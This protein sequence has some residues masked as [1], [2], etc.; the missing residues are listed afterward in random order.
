MTIYTAYESQHSHNIVP[1]FQTYARPMQGLSFPPSAFQPF[2]LSASVSVYP[3]C[4]WHFGTFAQVAIPQF[5]TSKCHCAIGTPVS[6]S[7]RTYPFVLFSTTHYLSI[8]YTKRTFGHV[9]LLSYFDY[10]TQKS[11]NIAIDITARVY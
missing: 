7:K 11:G 3:K 9:L 8:F 6:L 1:T 10:R 4:H 5:I 2:R